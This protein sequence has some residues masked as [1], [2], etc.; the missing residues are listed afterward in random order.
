M[1]VTVA[2]YAGSYDNVAERLAALGLDIAI[3]LFNGDGQFQRD[4]TAIDPGNVDI[5]YLWFSP[6]LSGDMKTAFKVALECRSLKVLQT[7]NAG[8]DHPGYKQV[9]ARGIRITNSSAQAIAISE[10]VMGQVLAVFQPIGEQRRLQVEKCWQRTP[11][12]EIAGTNWLIIGFGPIGREVAGRAK[13]FGATIDVV[14]RS[15]E[16]GPTVDRAGTQ[17]DLARFLPDADV[18]VLACPLN[19]ATRG[20]L[21]GAFFGQLKTGAV[22]V[23][24]ARGG[25]ID[26]AALI[27]ALDDGRA[28]TAVLDVFH[29][30]PLPVDSPLWSHPQIR[31]TS[32][33]SFAGSGVRSRWE[34]LFLDNIQRYVRGE[35]LVNEV[36]PEDI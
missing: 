22:L 16:T 12:R 4:G 32:H 9:A 24:I 30:E 18:V 11:F 1:P 29:A 3:E 2:M 14:R 26:D 27:A 31:L 15:P 13:A 33:T 25:L 7:F 10:Y 8:L 20:M 34:Q 21:D 36:R 35:A 17:A 19:E 23:N 28:A 6:E 5:D